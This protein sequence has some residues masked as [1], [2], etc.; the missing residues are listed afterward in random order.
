MAGVAQCWAVLIVRQ[1]C[2][3][4]E[5]ELL[6][7]PFDAPNWA[8]RPRRRAMQSLIKIIEATAGSMSDAETSAKLVQ[9]T[10]IINGILSASR[11]V[12][13][14]PHENENNRAVSIPNMEDLV[15]R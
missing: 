14:S 13:D 6:A 5:S 12:P 8:V 2:E 7:L 11:V 15:I 4:A 1:I 3:Q 10:E 9:I